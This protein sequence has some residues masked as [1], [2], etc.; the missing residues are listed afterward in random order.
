M[1]FKQLGADLGLEEDEYRELIDIFIESTGVALKQLR[2]AITENDFEN[3]LLSAHTIK[4]ASGNLGLKDINALACK[5]ELQVINEKL[6]SI[7]EDIKD[8]SA[9]FKRIESFVSS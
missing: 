2:N 8:L 7:Y 4:G 9:Y 6:D 5:I 3:M 1:N